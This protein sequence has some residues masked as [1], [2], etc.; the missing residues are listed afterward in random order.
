MKAVLWR[1]AAFIVSRRPVANRLIRSAQRTP[2]KPITGRSSDDLYM[3]RWW[4]FNPYSKDAEGK[5]LP[6]RWRWLPSI[7]VH[8]IVRPDDDGYM[9]DH[10]WDA[11]TIVLQGW[12]EEERPYTGI[13]NDVGIRYVAGESWPRQIHRRARGY[14]GP[15]RV[16]QFHRI[17]AVSPG[18]VHTLWFTWGTSKGWGFLV[19]G[20]KVPCDKHLGDDAC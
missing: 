19:D 2:Y 13:G 17:S 7:R 1:L 4:V 16:G 3:D 14:T 15:V 18:G 11:R 5:Q 12:Y 20:K 8:H 9:H 10:P 6:A